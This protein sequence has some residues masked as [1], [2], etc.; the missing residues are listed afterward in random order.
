MDLKL[1]AKNK[2]FGLLSVV[3]FLLSLGC[4]HSGHYSNIKAKGNKNIFAVF[5]TLEQKP[6]GWLGGSF[7]IVFSL[8]SCF[9]TL[10]HIHTWYSVSLLGFVFFLVLN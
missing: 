1:C 3:F 4:A 5:C 6:V 10:A 8:N 2:K 7:F 9:Y